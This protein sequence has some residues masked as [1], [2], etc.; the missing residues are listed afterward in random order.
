MADKT[1]GGQIETIRRH[2]FNTLALFP[3]QVDASD[4][5]FLTTVI[6]ILIDALGKK[7]T[8]LMSK[9]LHFTKQQKKDAG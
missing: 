7:G 4:K 5:L 8:E 3:D 1:V 2:A 6:D 9:P